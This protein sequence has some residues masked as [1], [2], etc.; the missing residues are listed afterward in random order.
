MPTF[1]DALYNVN[2]KCGEWI[3]LQL[4]DQSAWAFDSRLHALFLVQLDGQSIV[5]S[6]GEVVHMEPG[7]ITILLG[8]CPH[9]IRAA[10]GSPTRTYE[11]AL[12]SANPDAPSVRKFGSGP[13]AAELLV[14]SVQVSW[15]LGLNV[16]HLPAVMRMSM[17]PTDGHTQ[18]SLSVMQ[19]AATGPGAMAYLTKLAEL[20]FLRAMREHP[21]FRAEMV[22]GGASLHISRAIRL[23]KERPQVRWTLDKLAREVG[24]S[25]SSFAAKFMSATDSTPMAMLTKIRLEIA[26]QL[27]SD[28]RL[29]IA[30]VAG[31]VG[32]ESESAFVRRFKEEYGGPPGQLR[33][34]I[35]ADNASIVGAG[36][37]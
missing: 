32:Y 11:E 7:H 30:E 3:R 23:M 28:N 16:Q 24:I 5:S 8:E 4:D 33:R 27:L 14:G 36:A 37:R 31:R 13:V 9:T 25:R 29:S 17:M 10:G 1:S 6:A 19:R 15:P 35:K 20:F 21:E 22:G 34:S 2:A 26:F 12:R 18:A